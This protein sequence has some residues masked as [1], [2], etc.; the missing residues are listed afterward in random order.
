MAGAVCVQLGEPGRLPLEL[1]ELPVARVIL[2]ELDRDERRD[3]T[4]EHDPNQEQRRQAESQRRNM[5]KSYAVT[6][7]FRSGATL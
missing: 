1:A 4:G 3:Q 7:A 5:P 6:G 2:E